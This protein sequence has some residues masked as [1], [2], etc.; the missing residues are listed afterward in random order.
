M[1]NMGNYQESAIHNQ[2]LSRRFSDL[3]INPPGD[4]ADLLRRFSATPLTMMLRLM[5]RTIRVE[6]NNAALLN[7]ARKFFSSHQH[8]VPTEAEFVWKLICEA[9]MSFQSSDVPLSAFSDLQLAYVNIG[10]RGFMAVDHA[11]REAVGYLSDVFL[12]DEPRFRHRPP[13]DILFCMTASSLGLVS[14]SGGCVAADGRGVMVFGPPNSGKTTSCYLAARS[15]LEF[16]A[17][18]LVFLDARLYCAW[19]DPFPA[20]FRL[21]SLQFL[22]ELQTRIHRS[23]YEHSMFGYFDK[24]DM[25]AREARPIAPI[26]SLFLNRDSVGQPELR[27]IS[28]E[29]AFEKLRRCVLFEEDHTVEEQISTVVRRLAEMPVYE[30]RYEKDPAIAARY[31]ENLMR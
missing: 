1:A 29:E 8:G 30:L 27:E 22:P 26:C 9:D 11:K 15:G 2:N 4:R 17:D 31:I 3:A 6:S 13:Q 16:Q 12:G 20:V 21:E 19:G 25:Q 18:Q 5:G 10:Q 28:P 23:R 24:S 14:M 7:L